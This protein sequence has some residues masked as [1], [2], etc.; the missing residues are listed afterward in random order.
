MKEGYLKKRMSLL[1]GYKDQWFQ[2][3]EDGF[4][5]YFNEKPLRGNLKQRGK[6]FL[7]LSVTSLK[8][9]LVSFNITSA[10][11]EVYRLRADTFEK[12]NEWVQAINNI[13][14]DMY[15]K[16]FRGVYD[17]KGRQQIVSTSDD[18]NDNEGNKE[19]VK[20]M[21][22]TVCDEDM[23]KPEKNIASLFKAPQK[24]FVAVAAIDFGTTYSGCAFSTVQDFKTDK[25]RIVT[26]PLDDKN[27]FS[28]KTPTVLLLNPE[29][30]FHSFGAT[31][32]DHYVTLAEN[33]EA[34]SWYYF[35]R[36][37]MQLYSA[38][39]FLDLTNIQFHLKYLLSKA[40]KIL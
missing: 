23:A 6:L 11:D 9:D 31:A 24:P 2:L 1:N 18:E 26:I 12:R 15:N 7:L 37:K 19:I 34:N 20:P 10:D 14:T 36:F 4:L 16:M 3:S 38:K 17:T 33:D 22:E 13:R 25:L 40:L 39:V 35:D 29:G 5:K 32:E 8:K 27:V 28:Y 21:H 30:H